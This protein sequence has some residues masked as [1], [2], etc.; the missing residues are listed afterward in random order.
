M[1][2]L[3]TIF[4]Q[5]TVDLLATFLLHSLWIGACVCLLAWVTLALLRHAT[6]RSKCQLLLLY[7][8]LI[9]CLSVTAIVVDSDR[10]SMEISSVA[11]S[12]PTELTI[13][14]AASTDS[15]LREAPAPRQSNSTPKLPGEMSPSSFGAHS[16]QYVRH[17]QFTSHSQQRADPAAATGPSAFVQV[18]A[19]MVVAIWLAGICLLS[20]RMVA[21]WWHLRQLFKNSS[22]VE[23]SIARQFGHILGQ[24]GIRVPVQ[25]RTTVEAVVPVTFGCLRPI[26]LLPVSCIS[27]LS[28]SELETLLIHEL[29]HIRRFDFAIHLLQR[30]V[31]IVF[32]YHPGV[33]WLSAQIHQEREFACD[34]LV[35]GL[36]SR[37]VTY[38]RALASIAELARPANLSLAASSGSLKRRIERIVGLGEKPRLT[39]LPVISL[40][41]TIACVCLLLWG[42]FSSSFLPFFSLPR[43][44]K[45]PA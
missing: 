13:A 5:T 36:T 8:V 35:V 41:S 9:P 17:Q 1:I 44:L 37:R 12:D 2:P 25:V 14:S 4:N 6:A 43:A 22:D 18:F 24:L 28:I 21:D 7:L 40:G 26:V 29:A 19:R 11:P 16:V 45:Q 15:P 27:N 33:W 42:V 32:F 39:P 34:D 23:G 3:G 38:A 10:R 30:C 31:E 20:L